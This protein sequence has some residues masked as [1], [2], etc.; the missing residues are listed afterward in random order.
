MTERKELPTKRQESR[1]AAPKAGEQTGRR[2]V[3]D[4]AGARVVGVPDN[5]P[6]NLLATF[7]ANLHDGLSN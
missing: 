6:T 1:A 3:V 2:V 5:G 7:P 4:G